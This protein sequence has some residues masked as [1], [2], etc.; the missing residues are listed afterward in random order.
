MPSLRTSSRLKTSNA[1]SSS[2]LFSKD[3]PII[4]APSS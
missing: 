1:L 4:V 2:C 3:I